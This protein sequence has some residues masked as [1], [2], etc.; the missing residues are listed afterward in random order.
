M[1]RLLLALVCLAMASAAPAAERFEPSSPQQIEF[2]VRDRDG[3][4]HQAAEFR[5]R[6]TLVHFWA[7]WCL[8][9][10]EELPALV[11]LQADL[12]P[13]GVK[14]VAV[15]VDRLGW[16]AIDRTVDKLGVR[17]LAIFHD[18]DR[19]TSMA[20]HVRGLPTTIAV[21]AQGRE[22]ARLKGQGD[23]GDPALRTDIR[24]LA[25]R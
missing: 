21:D 19:E 13:D 16:D 1:I 10:R 17:G 11:K 3:V 8:P 18:R 6:L 12:A 4:V 2:Q 20:L 25:A 9:C 15:S 22:L 14:I 23:W 7:T 24:A 5:A